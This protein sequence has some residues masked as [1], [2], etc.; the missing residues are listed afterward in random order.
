MNWKEYINWLE[1]RKTFLLRSRKMLKLN[2]VSILVYDFYS[3]EIAFIDYE[4]ERARRQ[5]SE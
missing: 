1:K 3:A 5:R 4:I 2:G